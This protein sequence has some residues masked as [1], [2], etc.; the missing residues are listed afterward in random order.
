MGERNKMVK[1]EELS[2][3]DVTITPD[4]MEAV[5]IEIEISTALEVYGNV[6]KNPQQKIILLTFENSKLGVGGHEAIPYYEKEK[7]TDNTTLGKFLLKYEKLSV[8]TVIDIVKNEKGF[9]KIKYY[10]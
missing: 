5:I 4:E 8:G 1:I 9:Y 3:K 2:S 10:G 6:T 7:L